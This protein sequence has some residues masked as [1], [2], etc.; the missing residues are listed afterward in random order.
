[1]AKITDTLSLP[2]PRY[3]MTNTSAY[4]LDH[5]GNCKGAAP[6]HIKPSATAKNGLFTAAQMHAALDAAVAAERKRW[7]DTFA[8]MAAMSWSEWDERAYLLD[9]G[10]AIALDHAANLLKAG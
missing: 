10:K 7:S 6:V 4:S 9:Q 2:T 8:N 1:M 3:W 5:G